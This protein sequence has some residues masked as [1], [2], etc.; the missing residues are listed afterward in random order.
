M[1]GDVMNP[2]PGEECKEMLA[3]LSTLRADLIAEWN[4]QLATHV[5]IRLEANALNENQKQTLLKTMQFNE[6]KNKNLIATLFE[7]MDL[8]E[9]DLRNY[10]E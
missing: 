3:K 10:I 1:D 4:N 8:L 2:L 9:A 6:A 5:G 7:S